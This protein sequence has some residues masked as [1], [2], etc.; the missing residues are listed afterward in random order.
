MRLEEKTIHQ[1]AELGAPAVANTHRHG[2]KGGVEGW[3][4]ARGAE[5]LLSW[6]TCQSS[7]TAAWK[8]IIVHT[9]TETSRNFSSWGFPLTPHHHPTL[10]QGVLDVEITKKKTTFL[11]LNNGPKFTAKGNVG[12]GG[13]QEAWG[14]TLGLR[15]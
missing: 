3:G 7:V 2:N 5:L 9:E 6:V 10:H 14:A 11:H 13:G 15:S 1:P 4:A 8:R 12:C